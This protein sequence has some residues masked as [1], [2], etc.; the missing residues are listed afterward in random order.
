MTLTDK[1]SRTLVDGFLTAKDGRMFNGRGEE[2]LLCGMGLGNW[3]LPEGYMWRFSGRYDRPR[4]IEALVRE[5]CGSTFA[6]SLWK[7]FRENYIT[8]ADVRAMAENGFNSVRLPVNWRV[9]MED[10]PGITWKE[11]G[12]ALIERFLD[13]CEKYSCTSV[14]ICTARPA[15]RPDTTS[16]TPLTIFRDC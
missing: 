12:F 13:W 3:L 6:E 1:M 16:T 9:V 7:R 2:I 15:V 4:T 5:L 10:E 8:E 14:W 11:D